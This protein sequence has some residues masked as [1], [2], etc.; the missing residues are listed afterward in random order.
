M[1]CLHGRKTPE[2][3]L[4][5]PDDLRDLPGNPDLV[6]TCLDLMQAAKLMRGHLTRV[7]SVQYKAM[8]MSTHY[9]VFEDVWS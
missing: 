4:V 6:S 9:L 5:H 3:T 2:R 7:C 1:V 8:G